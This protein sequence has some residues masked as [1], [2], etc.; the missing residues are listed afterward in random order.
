MSKNAI[1]AFTVLAFFA[2]ANLFARPIVARFHDPLPKVSGPGTVQL[3]MNSTPN[4]HQCSG[5]PVWC[6][7]DQVKCPTCSCFCNSCANKLCRSP[8]NMQLGQT[9]ITR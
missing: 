5:H 3:S 4:L 1:I 9:V 6:N 8:Q 2:T 7:L